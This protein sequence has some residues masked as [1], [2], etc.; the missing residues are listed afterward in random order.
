MNI[1]LDALS[2]E[3]LVRLRDTITE[4]LKQK[5]VERQAELESELKKLSQYGTP[6]KKPAAPKKKT[7][8]DAQAIP[9]A[10]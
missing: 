8:D 1:D 3:D 6:T 2:I 7:K 9:K 4:K 5:V 10:A